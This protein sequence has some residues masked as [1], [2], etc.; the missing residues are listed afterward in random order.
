VTARDPILLPYQRRWYAL[1]RKVPMRWRVAEKSRQIGLTWCEAVR[2]ARIA[3]SARSAGGRRCF[4]VSTSLR[5]AKEYIDTAALWAK[6]MHG[7][8]TA[9]GLTILRDGADD[10]LAHEIRFA[11]GF[12]VIAGASNPASLRSRGGEVCL[13]EFAHHL[14]AD[15][16][17]KAAFALTQWGGSVTVIST[18]NGARNRFVSLIDEIKRGVQ[19]GGHMRVTLDDAL[20]DHLYRR[21]CKIARRPWTAEGEAQFR[22]DC[23]AS[24]GADEEFRCIPAESGTVFYRRDLLEQ[25]AQTGERRGH[26]VHLQRPKDWITRPQPEREAETRAWCEAR[27]GPLL[28]ASAVINPE[29]VHYLGGDYGRTV[30]L[31]AFWVLEQATD[32]SLSSPL[33]VELRNVPG[34][35]QEIVADFIIARLARARLGG[36]GIDTSEGGGYTLAEGLAGTWGWREAGTE[37]PGLILPIKLTPAWYSRE[38]HR[39]RARLEERDISI[40]RDE[41]VLG[42][43]GSWKVGD[44]GSVRLGERTVS[45]RDKGQ[46]HGDASVACLIAQ[47]LAPEM[48]Q[49]PKYPELKASARGRAKGWP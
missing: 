23:L 6:A 48:P 12:A 36:V 13:D 1:G 25:C 46:R 35:E 15:E 39:L 20:A 31:S 8:A 37:G 3:A 30:D 24:P 43:F 21:I 14:Q 28:D 2:Q 9:Q 4:Y 26:I 22:A 41:D 10:I 17:L 11:S 27:L 40:F 33:L 29:R 16:L 49:A 5:L 7:Y 45:Q 34:K 38:H 47:S 19:S 32:L 18:H 42:D 44:D